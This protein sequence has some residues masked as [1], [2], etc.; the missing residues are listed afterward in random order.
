MQDKYGNL[1]ARAAG[2]LQDIASGKKGEFTKV[3]QEVMPN[4]EDFVKQTAVIRALQDIRRVESS[5]MSLGIKGGIIGGG[6]LGGVVALPVA[7][8]A[9]LLTS[10]KFVLPI[11]ER[12]AR[13]LKDGKTKAAAIDAKLG[14]G[15]SLN[16]GQVQFM[17]EALQNVKPEEVGQIKVVDV[18]NQMNNTLHQK[19]ADGMPEPLKRTL[20]SVVDMRK[21]LESK[22][23]SKMFTEQY[24]QPKFN[25]EFTR[26]LNDLKRTLG[27]NPS[28]SLA[29]LM[30]AV[31][32]FMEV[33]MNALEKPYLGEIR[34]D[35]VTYLLGE[36]NKQT[37]GQ[38]GSYFERLGQ[39]RAAEPV[40]AGMVEPQMPQ[41]TQPMQGGMEPMQ[42]EPPP[43]FKT[44][45][46]P[47]SNL[48]IYK[49][50]SNA[51]IDQFKLPESSRGVDTLGRGVYLTKKVARAKGYGDN[52]YNVEVSPDANIFSFKRGMET[53][54]AQVSSI[55]DALKKNGINV[56]ETGKDYIKSDVGYLDFMN[57]KGWD[58]M[59]R[60]LNKE[61]P[62]LTG[63]VFKSLGYDGINLGDTTAIFS[64]EKLKNLGKLKS[65]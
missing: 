19:I 35:I 6:I 60:N 40:T 37:N 45:A 7:L 27:K 46:T 3:L 8:G 10:P 18:Y 65:N 38:L 16:K 32:K 13:F 57:G 55:A 12:G 56:E 1:T 41:P 11:I 63:K 33:D 62:S 34:K 2:L 26:Q 64:P 54:P 48:N 42:P 44:G 47:E 53:S 5:K 21:T 49:H 23:L 24:D 61:N 43:G 15:E 52:V 31:R 25:A 59:L 20:V 28:L 51:E 58:T 30:S 9:L 14:A 50:G 22:K 36:A 29:S 17:A 39:P 4:W